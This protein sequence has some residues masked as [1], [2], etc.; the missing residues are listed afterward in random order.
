LHKAGVT[1]TQLAIGDDYLFAGHSEGTL[2]AIELMRILRNDGVIQVDSGGQT[3]LTLMQE[4]QDIGETWKHSLE[5]TL[6]YG[7]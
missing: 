1:L 2:S 4:K 7:S 6:E 5:Y 3:L